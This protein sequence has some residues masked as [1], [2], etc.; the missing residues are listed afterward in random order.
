MNWRRASIA[1]FWASMMALAAAA[2]AEDVRVSV[3]PAAPTVLTGV[4]VP[5]TLFRVTSVD[6]A[7]DVE[8][9]VYDA[10]GR[11]ISADGDEPSAGLLLLAQL[12]PTVT[13]R[14]VTF[15]TTCQDV[16]RAGPGG[17]GLCK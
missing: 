9:F 17:A 7:Q 2:V 13:I 6:F 12:T 1:I 16:L 3:C 8:V 5:G 15:G 10:Y 11:L 4:P 14:I